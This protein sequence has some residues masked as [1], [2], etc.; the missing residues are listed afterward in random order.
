VFRRWLFVRL[1]Q[2]NSSNAD[3]DYEFLQVNAGRLWVS[4]TVDAALP[5]GANVIG[6]L[7][8]NQS[9]N[10]NQI[11]GTA[12]ATGNGVA[13]AGCQRVTIASDNS[14]V[15]TRALTAADVVTANLAAGTNMV[16]KFALAR[17]SDG[18]EA[19]LNN[20]ASDALSASA[21]AGF[22]GASFNYIYNG[23]SWD[24]ARG[25]TAN[26]MDVDVTRLPTLTKGTQGA[27]GASTQDLKDAGRNV[28]NYFM[29]LPII[30]TATDA[31]VSLT[32]YK[33][34]AAVA[35]AT[36][37]AVV[38][39][40]K[41]YRI[42]SVIL[43]YVAIATAGSAKVSLRANLTGAVVVGSPVVCSWVIGGPAAAA[44]VSQSVTIDIPDGLEFAAGA[45][46][47]VTISGLS[48]TQAAAATGYVQVALSGFEY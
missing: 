26:G 6:A 17:S 48:A 46:I 4:A 41:T 28:T 2:L 20:F 16:G 19:T 29:A 30:T 31:L 36:A 43:T 37:P 18:F 45:G 32:G 1:L 8:A 38:T 7:V 3:G 23:A 13:G 15:P 10:L 21:N 35:A 34:G 5:A 33:G 12:T 44:G 47:G 9:V 42:T 39:T 25:D 22:Y 27:T 11:A 14:A 24:R 40:G